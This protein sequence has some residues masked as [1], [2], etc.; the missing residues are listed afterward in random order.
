MNYIVKGNP[1]T[2]SEHSRTT[3]TKHDMLYGYG[4]CYWCGNVK[5]T[6]YRY[7]DSDPIELQGQT[8]NLF[9]S[10]SCYESTYC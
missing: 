9:C 6:M 3:Y 8:V 10:K 7:N 4:V 2:H 5:T 1:F